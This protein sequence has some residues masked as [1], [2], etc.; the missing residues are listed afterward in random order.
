[1]RRVRF[2]AQGRVHHGTWDEEGLRDET[3]RV[4]PPDGVTW[5][6][7]VVPSKILGFALTYADHAAELGVARPEEPVLFFKPPSALV[8]H[9]VPVIYPAGVAYLHYE[10]ELA[11]VIGRRCRRV[12]PEAVRDLV[13]GYTVANDVTARDFVGTFYRPPVKAK[14]W[15]TF[16]PLGPALVD[17]VPAPG[18][19]ALRTFVNGELRQE[20]NTRH[21][22]YSVEELVAYL[23]AFMTLEEDDVI[24]TGTPGGI[25][26][27]RPG[28]VMRVEVE[29]VG[30]LEN[31]VVAEEGAG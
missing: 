7:P 2:L 11:V 24:L 1:M 31:P 4:W 28:D 16:L 12:R 21:L 19:L 20:G 9:R 17:D 18:D 30:V 25:S 3:G 8:G 5:L 13:K 29:G 10:A 14:G 22:L 27:V 15:D 6:P 26:P 23:S